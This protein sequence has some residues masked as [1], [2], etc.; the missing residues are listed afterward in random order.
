M[1]RK[2]RSKDTVEGALEA[3]YTGTHGVLLMVRDESDLVE[4]V[5]ASKRDVDAAVKRLASGSYSV[6]GVVLK[7]PTNSQV[8][9]AFQAAR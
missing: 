1:A 2:R 4:V 7:R 9:S 6:R 5:G 8:R 3:L